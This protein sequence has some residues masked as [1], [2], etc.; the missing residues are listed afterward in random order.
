M[1]STTNWLHSRVYCFSEKKSKRDGIQNA[2]LTN[3]ILSKGK[4]EIKML[5][6]RNFNLEGMAKA[7]IGDRI[8]K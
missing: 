7:M 5:S 3:E 1:E 8:Y 4:K 6:S 2:S